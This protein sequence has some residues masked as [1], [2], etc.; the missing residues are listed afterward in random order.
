LKF[1]LGLT[2]HCYYIC[3]VECIRTYLLFDKL[4]RESLSLS[5][6]TLHLQLSFSRTHPFTSPPC[7]HL[8]VP[9]HARYDFL[10][11][12]YAAYELRPL[13]A[14]L[15]PNRRFE[16]KFSAPFEFGQGPLRPIAYVLELLMNCTCLLHLCTRHAVT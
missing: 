3:Q 16:M 8:P 12:L 14:G 9:Q 13:V 1:G 15:N 5:A 4:I 7:Q 2:I 11:V 10:F 6:H